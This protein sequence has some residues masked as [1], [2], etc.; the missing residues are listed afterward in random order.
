MNF[1]L[2]EGE[3]CDS[4]SPKTNSNLSWPIGRTAPVGQRASSKRRYACLSLKR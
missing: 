4:W 3:T 1:V 2:S